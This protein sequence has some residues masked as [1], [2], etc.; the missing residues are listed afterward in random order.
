MCVSAPFSMAAPKMGVAVTPP[1]NLLV[2]VQLTGNN[3]TEIGYPGGYFRKVGKRR[4]VESSTEGTFEFVEEARGET[5]VMLYD[6]SR[7]VYI[8]LDIANK[9]VLYGEGGGEQFRL[10]YRITR[11][12]GAG[13]PPSAGGGAKVAANCRSVGKLR[14]QNSDVPISV[15]FRN[16]TNSMR[17]V[18]WI[19]FEGQP[20]NY[21]DLQPGQ[22]I[23]IDTYVTHP[24]MMTDGPGNC[25][26][27]FMPKQ[28]VKRFDITAAD[29][30]GGD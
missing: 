5:T 2:L 22:K 17:S 19:N 29:P 20:E 18:M 11:L 26:E 14:S 23:T 21:A 10:L 4:W 27:V 30:G 15:T 3:V 16:K 24:W 7:D 1:G 12:E 6:A 28:G 8:Q 13:A 25:A 9:E